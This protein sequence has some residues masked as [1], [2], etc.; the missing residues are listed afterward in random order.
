MQNIQRQLQEYA[1]CYE[2]GR[3]LMDCDE[4]VLGYVLPDVSWDDG[5]PMT[6]CQSFANHCEYRIERLQYEAEKRQGKWPVKA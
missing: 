5:T 4:C 2:A 3:P 6:L 1:K